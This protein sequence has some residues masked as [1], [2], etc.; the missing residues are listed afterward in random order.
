VDV[1]LLTHYFRPEVGAPQERLAALVRGL[2]S[3][4]VR[5]AVHAPFPHYPDGA[6]PPPYRNRPFERD[7]RLG[8][9]ARV[10]RSAVYP[11][12][13]RDVVRRLANHASF[14]ASSL[15]TAPLSGPA[16]V[17]VVESPPLFLAA[18][19]VPYAAAKRAALVVNVADRW[20]A[21]AVAL[22][23]LADPRAIRAAEALERWCYRG[24]DAVTV[25]TEGLATALSALPEA[26]GKVRRLAPA[27]DLER[28]DPAP[29]AP[30]DGPLRV[31]YAGT[32]GMAQGLGTL[33]E[34]AR[35]AGPDTVQVTIAGGG[36][37]LAAVRREVANRDVRNVTLLGVVPSGQVPALH[38][39]ADAAVVLLRDR[40][41]FHDALPTK[42]L[43]AM[44]AG[45]ALVLAARGESARLVQGAGA[46][47]VVPPEDP[48]ALAAAL[49]A[50]HRDRR[51]VAALGAAARAAAERDF[52]RQ[53]MVARWH[54]LLVEV[55]RYRTRR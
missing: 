38:R 41:I 37:E 43:E 40:P 45:R 16:D 33:V 20:P 53:R 49:V 3:R 17:V 12:A 11:A 55:A 24:A 5:V 4:G 51:R 47:V 2:A 32:V 48:G 42:T 52:T 54:D 25:P 44:A 46:G 15:L 7:R 28:F 6:V 18:A 35:R 10:H 30:R 27:V 19:A 22:G 8:L 23:A 14:A 21:S 26:A 1:L 50:L 9:P 29:P 31:L 36:A 39:A 13:N 34:A